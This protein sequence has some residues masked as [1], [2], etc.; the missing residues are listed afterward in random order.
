MKILITGAT[1]LVGK[2]LGRELAARGHNLIVI[3]RD[4]SKAACDLPFPCEVIEGNLT[5]G[6]IKDNRLKEV[7]AV[8]HLMGE[9]IAARRWTQKQK[10]RLVDSRVQS[11]RHLVNSLDLGVETFISASA[12]GF[13]GDRGEQELSEL[14]G[15]G[16]GYLSDL[17]L[18][19]EKAV[20]QAEA[21]FNARTV[22]VR[23]AMVLSPRGGALGRMIPPFRAGL[24]VVFGHGRQWVSWIHIKDAVRLICHALENKNLEG[25][26]N[27]SSPLP[28]TNRIFCQTLAR[29]LR[30][31]LGPPI[32]AFVFKILCGEL[33]TVFLSS[34]KVIPAKA[35]DSG[36]SFEF[37]E[38]DA[39]L[40]D[41]I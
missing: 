20:D 24:G 13:Y 5:Q 32:P 23:F 6:P 40:R 25:P 12:V 31:P 19:W 3:S 15:P 14:D 7:R 17:V 9:N 27:A 22:K 11:T 28:V 1:G 41:L 37:P 18:D 8:I 4:R 36:F 16:A 2:E 39:A 33:S 29:I 30:R 26:L 35:L 21:R 34:Q 38:L 10:R